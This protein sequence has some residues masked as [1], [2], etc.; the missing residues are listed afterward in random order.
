MSKITRITYI[1]YACLAWYLFFNFLN[2]PLSS[3]STLGLSTWIID[4]TEKHPGYNGLISYFPATLVLAIMGLMYGTT[5]NRFKLGR[6][7]KH[8][9]WFFGAV[10]LVQMIS[11]TLPEESFTTNYLNVSSFDIP[12]KLLLALV[13]AP[14]AEELLFRG[15]IP[16]IFSAIF[17]DKIGL[18]VGIIFSSILFGF[19]HRQYGIETQLSLV[20]LGM[21]L[22]YA[23]IFSGGF[24]LPFSLH[25]IAG[26]IAVFGGYLQLIN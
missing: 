3:W 6:W 24:L 18:W 12:A 16:E 17:G 7:N 19:I 5:T 1:L 26:F 9:L 4:F 8:W 15:F 13:C 25:F 21:I 22:G 20:A 2:W 23:R 10:S 14:I 11:F